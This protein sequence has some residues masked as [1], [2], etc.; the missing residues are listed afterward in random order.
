MGAVEIK[1]NE[2]DSVRS[3]V[4]RRAAFRL[5]GSMPVLVLPSCNSAP[6]T[7]RY[8]MTVEVE[9][10][11]GLRMG[12]SVMETRASYND[13]FLKGLGNA[14]F[15][16]T[17]GEAVVVDL[18]DRGLLFVLLKGDPARKGSG[19]PFDVFSRL[20]RVLWD[21]DGIGPGAMDRM[22]KVRGKTA[23]P[24]DMVPLLVR[25]RDIGDIE[26]AERIDPNDLAKSF[27][28]N[29]VLKQVSF[30]ITRDLVSYGVQEK[31]PWWNGPFLWLKPLGNGIYIDTRMDKFKVTKDQFSQGSQL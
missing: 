16:G 23:V 7:I 22:A 30:E 12:S 9:T 13:G 27:G 29:V 31:L 5:V 15:F 25:F 19:D 24:I 2:P 14:V 11:E 21:W 8:R 28:A 10:P 17:R 6:R 18:G 20:H 4:T 1:D 26:T 3:A